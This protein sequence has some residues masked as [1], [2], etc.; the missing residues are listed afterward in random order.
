MDPETGELV[1]F[2][3]FRDDFLV[4]FVEESYKIGGTQ[5]CRLT[6]TKDYYKK[7]FNI[8]PE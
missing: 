8:H 6:K 5:D 4:L 2:P 7:H 1:G 3:S